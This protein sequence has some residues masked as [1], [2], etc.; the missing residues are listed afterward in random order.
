MLMG[1]LLGDKKVGDSCLVNYLFKNQEIFYTFYTIFYT[2]A[3]TPCTCAHTHTQMYIYVCMYFLIYCVYFFCFRL[4]GEEIRRLMSAAC[5]G[6]GLFHL[7][8]SML[9]ST[10]LRLIQILGFS[11]DRMIGLDALM[12][13]RHGPDMRAPLA[14]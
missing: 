13:A 4:C 7:C 12:F 11:G 1:H 9:P 8:I 5:F 2:H 14:T 3:R 10:L 6:Y